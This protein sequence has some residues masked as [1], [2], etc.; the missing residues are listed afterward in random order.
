M[1]K[2]SIFTAIALFALSAVGC[3]DDN[4]ETPAPKGVQVTLQ[5]ECV[6]PE[7]K[8]LN[9]RIDI[10]NTKLQWVNGDAIGVYAGGNSN[11]KFTTAQ[12][13][14]IASFTGVLDPAKTQVGDPVYAY[15]PY[16]G[17]GIT[18]P[19]VQTQ[20]HLQFGAYTVMTAQ[21]EVKTCET[22]NIVLSGLRFTA[23]T[24]S[25]RF[26]VYGSLREVWGNGVSREKIQSVTIKTQEAVNNKVTFK[27]GNAIFS[28]G[29]DSEMTVNLEKE[30][31]MAY[32]RESATA[33]M[34]TVPVQDMTITEVVITTNQAVYTKTIDKTLTLTAGHIQPIYLNINTCKM[35]EKEKISVS[36][37]GNNWSVEESFGGRKG[38]FFAGMYDYSKHTEFKYRRKTDNNDTWYGFQNEWAINFGESSLNGQANI[39][40][41]NLDPKECYTIVR[42]WDRAYAAILIKNLELRGSFGGWNAG[43]GRMFTFQPEQNLWK[44]EGLKLTQG[45]Y[46]KVFVNDGAFA[47]VTNVDGAELN[48]NTPMACRRS[49]NTDG[50]AQ[51][52]TTTG[53]YNVLLDLTC[54]DQAVL[55]LEPVK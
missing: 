32:K 1:K 7:A 45:D 5:A 9:T 50:G 25:L 52:V 35:V 34:L 19:N 51:K 46:L 48:V 37:T 41:D 53:T 24:A 15:Y 40:N 12:Q 28:Q 16:A 23:Q 42:L 44:I 27:D 29:T 8:D 14:A 47:Y 2:L 18:L 39:K 49:G 55:V 22:E 3:S 31:A 11:A 26:H 6:N 54:E 21:G 17:G 20:K 10:N 36:G 13:D 33:L 38:D 4:S 30:Q 43:E